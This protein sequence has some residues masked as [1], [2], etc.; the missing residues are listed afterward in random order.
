MYLCQ[1]PFCWLCGCVEGIHAALPNAACPGLYQKLLD[2]TI[3][4]LLALY[5]PSSHQGNK[6]TNNNENIHLLCW[7]FLM[8]MVMCRYDTAH[9]T[10]WRRSRVT[11]EA[12]GCGHLASIIS[13]NIKGTYLHLFLSMFFHC[14]TLKMGAKK[15][16]PQLTIGVWHIKLMKSTKLIWQNTLLGGL[17]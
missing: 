2:A 16:W 3:G 12:I 6:Q 7:P 9:I 14:N 8:A 5:P 1:R 15:R 17:I 10:C 13:N 11:L 4:Q